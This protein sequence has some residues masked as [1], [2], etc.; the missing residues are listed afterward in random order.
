MKK[1]YTKPYIA[2]ESFQ[3]DAAIASS[4]SA[5]GKGSLGYTVDNCTL[6]DDKGTYAPALSLF[7]IA[8]EAA[9]NIDIVNAGSDGND[10]YCYHGPTIDVTTLF[11]NS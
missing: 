1:T 11:M 9:G 5:S 2:V 6:T 3:L 7:G 8:C 4:C 10:G